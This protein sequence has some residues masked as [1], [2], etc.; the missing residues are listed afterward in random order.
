MERIKEVIRPYYLRWIYYP[1]F[2]DRR[3]DYLSGCWR[4]PFE[5][6]KSRTPLHVRSS[7]LPDL[8]FFP[9][10]DW[11]GRMQRSQH[12][13]TAFSRLGYR[14][15][16][17]NP[18]FGRQFEST[19]LLDPAPRLSRLADNIFELHVRLPREPIFHHRMLRAEEERA[20]QRA[21]QNLLDSM[22]TR[23]AVQILSLPIWHGVARALREAAGFP[24]VYDCHDLL[25]GFTN[26]SADIIA[27]EAAIFRES[28]LLLFSSQDLL[29]RNEAAG[30]KRLLVRNAVEPKDFQSVGG[31]LPP[32]AVAGYVG[33]LQTWF[34]VDAMEEA[35]RS[36]P[37]CRFM[38]VG[39]I[40]QRDVLRL[41]SLPNVEFTGEVPY[42]R[43][44]QL[45]AQ[46][47]VGLIPFLVNGL[48]VA[49]NPIKLYEYFSYGMPVVSARIPEVEAF[50]DLVYTAST[51]AEFA[52]QVR[53]ALAEDDP[54]RRARRMAIARQ[55][56]WTARATAILTALQLTAAPG[57]AARAQS[58]GSS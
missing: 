58:A 17:L 9:M 52:V 30:K 44:P 55:E 10:C 3:P 46:F 20:I 4:Y 24:I 40:E 35:A 34:D 15:I 14:C 27:A 21:V 38:L 45:L 43:L 47:R 53:R 25:S 6:L 22:G 51:P 39:R 54:A 12:L 8:L 19:P 57:A 1:L 36:N 29:E 49:T 50:G 11:H 13:A 23:K 16:Y 33:A 37:L 28:D 7:S 18:H 32:Q 5:K 56:N 42:A 41:Q 48:T 2:P 26:I 31:T